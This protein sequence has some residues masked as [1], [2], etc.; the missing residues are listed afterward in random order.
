MAQQRFDDAVHRMQRSSNIS[1]EDEANL[2]GWL[3]QATVGDNTS[4]RPAYDPLLENPESKKAS[5]IE[6]WEGHE[7][8][9]GKSKEEAMEQYI[10]LASKYISD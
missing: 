3:K 6:L 10:A 4:R 5:A 9:R 1:R 7:R 8:C 2:R